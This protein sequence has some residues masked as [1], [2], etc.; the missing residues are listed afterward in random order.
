MSKKGN[1]VNIPIVGALSPDAVPE[2]KS[3]NIVPEEKSRQG[4]PKRQTP[5]AENRTISSD[6]ILFEKYLI[7][8]ERMDHK[9]FSEF[10]RQAIEYYCEKKS[11]DLYSPEL[12]D[13]ATNRYRIKAEKKAKK[14]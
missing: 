4:R 11:I 12:T 3:P 9:P 13:E 5:K 14:R 1:K 2:E 10:L 8:C 6:P 7:I